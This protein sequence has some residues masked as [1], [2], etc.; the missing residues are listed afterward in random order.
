MHF[1]VLDDFILMEDIIIDKA[2]TFDR[3]EQLHVAKIACA[4]DSN[5]IAIYEPS[6]YKNGP[7]MLI[8]NGFLTSLHGTNCIYKKKK[9]GKWLLFAINHKLVTNSSQKIRRFQNDML[10]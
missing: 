2:N 1:C 5:C 7:F 6:C 10:I 3:H 9:Y 8:K 4:K